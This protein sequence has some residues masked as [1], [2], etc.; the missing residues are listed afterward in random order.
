MNGGGEGGWD[1]TQ[2]G[3][4]KGIGREM[5]SSRQRG[6]TGGRSGTESKQREGIGGER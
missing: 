6:R 1:S 4:E 3:R 5:K 2:V